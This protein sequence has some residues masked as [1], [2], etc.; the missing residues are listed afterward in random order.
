MKR[1][2]VVPSIVLGLAVLVFSISLGLNS[3]LDDGERPPATVEPTQARA[4]V[5]L[6]DGESVTVDDNVISPNA[7]SVEGGTSITFEWSGQNEHWLVS[8][9]PGAFDSGR[10]DNGTY[11]FEFSVPGE[12]QIHCT[13][14]GPAMSA[15]IRVE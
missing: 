4:F 14:H 13:V 10:R 12:Y 7:F 8:T 9:A 15:V 5:A 2:A 6:A 3:L 1:I 11:E